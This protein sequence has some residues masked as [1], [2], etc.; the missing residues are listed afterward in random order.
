MIPEN[1]HL[2]KGLSSMARQWTGLDDSV[3]PEK[4]SINEEVRGTSTMT[5]TTSGVDEQDDGK[6]ACAHTVTTVNRPASGSGEYRRNLRE[7]GLWGRSFS[8]S[9]SFAADALLEHS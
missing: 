6:E 2:V 5:S 8:D 4:I 9:V 7:L 3:T 1:R